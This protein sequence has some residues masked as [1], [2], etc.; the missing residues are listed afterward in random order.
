MM[1]YGS[2]GLQDFVETTIGFE[3]EMIADRHSPV[4]QRPVTLSEP[5]AHHFD[6]VLS[7]AGVK[8]V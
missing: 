4:Y 1:E 6:R 5:E 3:R 8:A 2:R 7:V